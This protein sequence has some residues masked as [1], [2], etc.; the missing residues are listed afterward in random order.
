MVFHQ[1]LALSRL[2]VS[3]VKEYNREAMESRSSQPGIPAPRNLRGGMGPDAITM[4][5]SE[6][7]QTLGAPD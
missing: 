3:G 7:Y 1:P 4:T 6:A 2:G 5:E